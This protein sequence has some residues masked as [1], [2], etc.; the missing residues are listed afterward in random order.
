[1]ATKSDIT[2]RIIPLYQDGQDIIFGVS[3]YEEIRKLVDTTLTTTALSDEVIGADSIVGAAI[4]WGIEVMPADIGFTRTLEELTAKRRAIIFRAAG[5]VAPSVRK[6][7][8]VNKTQLE[9]SETQLQDNLFAAA[10]LQVLIA[11]RNFSRP[12]ESVLEGPFIVI[13]PDY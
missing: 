13:N 10:D 5:I 3:D 7:R 4:A 1:M 2:L 12:E 9:I 11:N 6:N 8:D